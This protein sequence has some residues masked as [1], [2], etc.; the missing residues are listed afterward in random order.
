MEQSVSNEEL[1]WEQP[2][3]W[4]KMLQERKERMGQEENNLKERLELKRKKALGWKLKRICQDI[5]EQSDPDWNKR[6]ELE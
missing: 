1:E 4:N 3:D 5:L 6:K 2:R